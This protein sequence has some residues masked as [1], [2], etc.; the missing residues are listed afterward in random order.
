VNAELR[1]AVIV[2]LAF[3]LDDPRP[4]R[5]Q[6]WAIKKGIISLRLGRIELGSF[7]LVYGLEH[8]DAIRS[9]WAR[10]GVDL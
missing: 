1:Q 7:S 9:W 3:E 6:E 5:F 10:E 8:E 4:W 2:N